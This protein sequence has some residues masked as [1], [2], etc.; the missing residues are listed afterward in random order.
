VVAHKTTSIMKILLL[1]AYDA[2]SHQYWRTGLQKAFAKHDWTILT[3]PARHF[4]WRIRGNSLSW[5]FEQSETLSRTYDLL[6]A[7]SMT[8]LSALRGMV[9]SLTHIPTLLYFHENQFAYPVSAH[10]RTT[11]EP[12]ILNLYSALCADKVAFNSQYNRNTFFVGAE[13]LLKKLPDHTPLRALQSIKDKADVLAVPIKCIDEPI[14]TSSNKPCQI[15]WNHRWEYDKGP[16]LLFDALL[17]LDKQL[18]PDSFTLHVVGQSFR[19]H[20]K[21]FDKIY[22]QFSHRIGQWGFL[23]SNNDYQNLLH[24]SDIVISTAIHDFQGI[25]VLEAVAAGCVP[26]VPNRLAY[27]ELFDAAFCFD[28]KNNE[29]E[30]LANALRS[31]IVE[32]AKGTLP[33][34]PMLQHLEWEQMKPQYQKLFDETLAAFSS[35]SVI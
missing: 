5:A 9:P 11:V 30:A 32:H 7:T 34:P 21:I 18:Q 1:S 4:S 27:P 28:D 26:V 31:R 13:H 16:D 10:G 2:Q 6:I 20:P 14:K 23:K 35:S 22:N 17:R 12:K 33:T 29:A 24:Q 3:L 15:V 8:D 19:Q 25:A